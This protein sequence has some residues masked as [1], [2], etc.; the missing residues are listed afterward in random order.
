MLWNG[1]I[2]TPRLITYRCR[3]SSSSVSGV[4][5]ERSADPAGVLDV[6]RRVGED[7]LGQLGG[8]AVGAGRDPAADRLADGHQIRVEA[9]RGGTASGPGPGPR[10]WWCPAAQGSAGH[11]AAMAGL[12]LPRGTTRILTR[13]KR[14][15]RRKRSVTIRSRPGSALVLA[16]VRGQ[17]VLGRQP[18]HDLV[19]AGNGRDVGVAALGPQI[20]AGQLQAFGFGRVLD[21]HRALDGDVLVRRVLVL[22]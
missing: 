18:E 12:F 1:V 9:P 4:A 10:G 20:P 21:G 17:P 8:E 6:R 14:E 5:R 7:P 13:I 16:V 22:G 3:Y 19:A 15:A 2:S 11:R